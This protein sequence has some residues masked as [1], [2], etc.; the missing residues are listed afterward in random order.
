MQEKQIGAESCIYA[1]KIPIHIIDTAGLRETNDIVE[2]K[3]IERTHAAIKH[4]DMVIWLVD[5]NQ[6]QICAANQVTSHIHWFTRQYRWPGAF[7]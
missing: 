6:Q 1:F 7:I 4:A 2:Q 5:S 3:G